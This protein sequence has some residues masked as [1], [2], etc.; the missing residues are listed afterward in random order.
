MPP[1]AMSSGWKGKEEMGTPPA[2]TGGLLARGPEAPSGA[3]VDGTRP[4]P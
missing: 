1:A 3:A 2:P 4:P